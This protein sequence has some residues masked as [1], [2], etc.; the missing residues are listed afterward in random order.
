MT[1]F[2]DYTKMIWFGVIEQTKM[3]SSDI[4]QSQFH[5]IFRIDIVWKNLKGFKIG[6]SLR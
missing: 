3:K 5:N 6:F 2:L 1:P 4:C